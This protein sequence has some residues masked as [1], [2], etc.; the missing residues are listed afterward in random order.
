MQVKFA[1]YIESIE[2]DCELQLL[3]LGTSAG[4]L[5]VISISEEN[6]EREEEEEEG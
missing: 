1:P 2:F 5:I 3:F 6:V 4:T